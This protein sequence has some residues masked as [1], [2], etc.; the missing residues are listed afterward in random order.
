M[1]GTFVIDLIL[2][3]DPVDHSGVLALTAYTEVTL[4]LSVRVAPLV[5]ATPVACVYCLYYLFLP[6]NMSTLQKAIFLCA[7]FNID[8]KTVL[9][10]NMTIF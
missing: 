10:P 2:Q 1:E 8:K 7:T 3:D 5:R 4:A 9:I 6:S